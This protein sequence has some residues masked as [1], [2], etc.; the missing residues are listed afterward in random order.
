LAVSPGCANCYAARLAATQQTARRIPIHLGTTNW[1][2]GNPAFNGKSTA[3]APGHSDWTWPI[4][5]PGAKHPLL[6]KGKPSLIFVVDMGDLF[7]EARPIEI[8][9]RVV[10]TITV[11]KHIGQFL[12]KRA[13]RMATYFAARRRSK[14]WLGFSA[15]RQLEFDQRWPPMRELAD[16]GWTVF[17]SIAPMLGPVVPPPDFLA[18]GDRVW[19]ICSGEQ[20]HDARYMHPAWVRALRDQCVE[21]GVPFFMRAMTNKE[22]IPPDLYIRQFPA[23]P[24]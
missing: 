12:T 20:A 18:H 13:E 1:V 21:A 14:D 2:R 8:I 7:H 22:L 19:V 16:A 4:T 11:S 24:P 15:E 10:V 23:L 17:A 3:L 9:D 6:G 5:W